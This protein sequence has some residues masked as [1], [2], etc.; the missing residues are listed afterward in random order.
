[1]ISPILAII[2]T[3]LFGPLLFFLW[4]RAQKNNLKKFPVGIVDGVGDIFLL[5]LFN[6]VSVT[7]VIF[8]IDIR[9]LIAVVLAY[10]ASRVFLIWRKNLAKSDDWTRPK[11]GT[12]NL[13]G[14]YHL[15]FLFVQMTFVLWSLLLSPYSL[16]LWSIIFLFTV[17]VFLR[18]KKVL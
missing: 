15:F 8:V 1:M 6:A 11:R 12:F 10:V 3:L 4:S 13:A 17:L 14:W 2:L 7:T 9:L 5:P 16:F 18:Y